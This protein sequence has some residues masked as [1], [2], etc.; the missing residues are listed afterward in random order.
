MP[1]N[2]AI[3]VSVVVLCYKASDL[4]KS[5]LDNIIL[6]GNQR[7]L[8]FELI[9]VANYWSHQRDPAPEMIKNYAEGIDNCI[10]ISK[11][12]KG[13]M[14]WDMRS[15]LEACKGNVLI[16]IDGDSQFESNLVFWAY[17]KL[18]DNNLDLCKTYRIQRDDGLYRKVI[19]K[20]FNFLFILLFPVKNNKD[21]IDINS[22]P[23]AFTRDAYEK[24]KLKS[25]DWFID[26]EIMINA[27]KNNFKMSSIP[28]RFYK[29]DRES[30]VKPIAIFEFLR[31]LIT[32]KIKSI[33]NN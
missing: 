24:M 14:G 18:I 28:I 29:S 2:K 25:S 21:Y 11:E 6:K 12:K 7:S 30:F 19:S 32:Y 17:D 3:E 20:I 16:V 4:I 26:S 33:K 23:K 9:L 13:N 31:N 27:R 5:F 8:N 10:V 1:K 22:K 15:G